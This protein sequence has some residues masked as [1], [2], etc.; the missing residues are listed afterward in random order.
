MAILS[1]YAAIPVNPADYA[2]DLFVS[3]KRDPQIEYWM[4]RVVSI[5]DRE[6]SMALGGSC[7]IF[8][9]RS[10]IPP[11]SN[12]QTMLQNA[13]QASRCVFG[14]WSPAY[15]TASEWCVTEWQSFKQ[16]EQFLGLQDGWI[17]F[18]VRRDIGP[19]PSQFSSIQCVDLSKHS[20]VLPAF[21]N[22]ERALQ[23]E[24]ALRL[25]IGDLAER[26]KRAPPFQP[27]FPF[28]LA[29][30]FPRPAYQPRFSGTAAA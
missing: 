13:T 24:D 2:I 28:T 7:D 20:S 21:W 12:W 30:P 25:L 19:F 14:F 11:G 9:D 10:S 26:I 8:F 4:S 29:K 27:A 1:D 18:P 17:T 3:Y 5:I 23:L 22:T 16:R 6:L 15:F